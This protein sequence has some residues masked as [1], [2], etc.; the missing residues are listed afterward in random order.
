MSIP[1]ENFVLTGDGFYLHGG[2][3][4]GQG[5]VLKHHVSFGTEERTAKPPPSTELHNKTRP[6]V[7]NCS[8]THTPGSLRST[9]RPKMLQE[10]NVQM[11]AGEPCTGSASTIL[12][13]SE[14]TGSSSRS[15]SKCKKSPFFCNTPSPMAASASPLSSAGKDHCTICLSSLKSSGA[16][17]VMR[18]GSGRTCSHSFH[19][20][21]IR[22][23]SEVTNACPLCNEEFDNLLRSDGSSF[24]VEKKQQANHLDDPAYWGGADPILEELVCIDCQKADNEDQLLVCDSGCGRAQH[25]YCAYLDSIPPGDWFCP[26][27]APLFCNDDAGIDSNSDPA[28]SISPQ[29][30]TSPVP[31][32]RRSRRAGM[33]IESDSDE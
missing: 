20:D 16:L 7:G 29:G 21:C 15:A 11:T 19:Y 24:R 25:T 22:Q 6:L 32:A 4:K 5:Q 8:P 28:L 3:V 2:H 30:G 26:E 27:C 14:T 10:D 31:V 9:K 1:H 18:K 17:A 12:E 13:I 33:I 23:W